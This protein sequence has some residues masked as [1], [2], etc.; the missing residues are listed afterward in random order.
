MKCKA[1]RIETEMNTCDESNDFHFRILFA[2]KVVML[3]PSTFKHSLFNLWNNFHF[4]FEPNA[5][6]QTKPKPPNTQRTK[7]KT[8]MNST[9]LSFV[10]CRLFISVIFRW[11]EFYH[12][13]NEET[14]H[15]IHN[16]H[17]TLFFKV[18]RFLF[19]VWSV[20]SFVVP[21]SLLLPFISQS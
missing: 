10:D 5:K 7:H 3:T 9:L 17:T 20:E 18:I 19:F 11:I 13:A 1:K 2:A 21:L 6:R 12:R 15:N 14:T 16:M 4:A 8:S